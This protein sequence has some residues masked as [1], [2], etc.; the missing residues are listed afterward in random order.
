MRGVA[1]FALVFVLSFLNGLMKCTLNACAF[2]LFC[3]DLIF[4]MHEEKKR[5]IRRK[6]KKTK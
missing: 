3:F 6:K 4:E 5:E 2:F 1:L